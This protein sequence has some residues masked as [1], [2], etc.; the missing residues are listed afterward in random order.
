[1]IKCKHCQRYFVFDLTESV[2]NE[3]IRCPHCGGII[4]L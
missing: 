2:E 3:I 4:E 1:M